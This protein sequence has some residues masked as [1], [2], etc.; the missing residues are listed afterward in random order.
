MLKKCKNV[1]AVNIFMWTVFMG[2]CLAI[3]G[4]K[5]TRLANEELV[6][7]M[8]QKAFYWLSYILGVNSNWSRRK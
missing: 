7:S 4:M 8:R 2:L 1:T 3:V 5:N 6:D